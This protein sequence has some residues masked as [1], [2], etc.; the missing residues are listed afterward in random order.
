VVKGTEI[1]TL[2]ETSGELAG[3]IYA[4]LERAGRLIGVADVL[5]AAI[6]VHLGLTLI[7]GNGSDYEHIGAVGTRFR[8]RAGGQPEAERLRDAAA[9]AY[10]ERRNDCFGHTSYAPPLDVA[11]SC[12][13][14]RAVRCSLGPTMPTNKRV[15]P[16]SPSKKT[17]TPAKAAPA[18]NTPA[19]TALVRTLSDAKLM[20]N[21]NKNRALALLDF[22]ARRTARMTED[23]YEVGKALKELLEKKLY[24]ALEYPSFEAMLDA[25][26]VMGATQARKLIEVVSRVPLKT[27][28]KLGLEKAFAMT[29]YTDATPEIDTPESLVEGGGEI[30][31]KPA[32]A[33]S[34]RE[35]EAETKKLRKV[36]AAKKG[37]VDAA[38][39]EA[40]IIA[41]RGA[42]WLKARGAKK[43]TVL[44]RRAKGG[45]V[46]AITLDVAEGA[47]LFEE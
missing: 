10:K 15:F 25:R 22:I 33:A 26:G 38:E 11:K 45:Y 34:R 31:G 40:S 6:A 8:S 46:L 36:A 20:T 23:F 41:R 19:K 4:D 35:I 18:K 13:A 29:R 44:A 1:V 7:T 39:R 16:E 9:P 5:I 3:R 28:L 21:A 37:K 42:A 17:A 47:A 2:D 14:S 43:A 12:W 30:G 24:V 27:A 32:V